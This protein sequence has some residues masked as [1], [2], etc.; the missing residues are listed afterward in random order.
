MASNVTRLRTTSPG[1]EE[2]RLEESRRHEKHW[3]CWGPYVSERAWVT[4]REDYSSGGIAWDDLPHDHARSRAYRWNEDGIAGISDRHQTLCFV[5][6]LWNGVDPILKER[7]FGLNGQKGNHGED[8]K[9]LYWYL[10]S[11]P[12][13]LLMRMLYK[14]PQ[15][16][17]EHGGAQPALRGGDPGLGQAGKGSRV[18]PAVGVVHRPAPTASAAP[19]RQRPRAGLRRSR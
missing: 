2:R 7:L 16:D 13:R 11:T 10:D 1:A 15:A 18:R 6:A 12:H 17:A 5:V 4:V 3:K 9:E 14:D 19:R 8:C